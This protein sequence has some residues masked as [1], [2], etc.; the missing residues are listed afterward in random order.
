MFSFISSAIESRP[1][2]KDFLLIPILFNRKII[3]SFISLLTNIF[4]LLLNSVNGLPLIENKPS[5]LIILPEILFGL[6][7]P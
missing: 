6:R 7:H 2:N 5:W 3:F 1:G 4:D